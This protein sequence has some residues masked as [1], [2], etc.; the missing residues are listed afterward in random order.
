MFEERHFARALFGEFYLFG[1]ERFHVAFHEKFEEG[2]ER[3]EMIVLGIFLE[4]FTIVAAFE[5]IEIQTKIVDHVERDRSG[6]RIF[7]PIDK[8]LQVKLVIAHR[9]MRTSFFDLDVFEEGT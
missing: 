7:G 6:V 2:A 4:G 5:P 1:R 8:S 3:D 9:E